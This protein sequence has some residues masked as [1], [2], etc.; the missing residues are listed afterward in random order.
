MSDVANAPVVPVTI[1]ESRC[2]GCGA[3]LNACPTG[4][5]HPDAARGKVSVR[6]PRDCHLCFLC[7]PDCAEGAIS[8]SYD[9]PN[10]R[11][12]SIYDIL[13]IEFPAFESPPGKA[14]PE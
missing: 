2:T 9:A 8:V 7:V 10:P 5:F 14:E 6:F 12:H 4:V 11:Q 13:A 3:C 1:D